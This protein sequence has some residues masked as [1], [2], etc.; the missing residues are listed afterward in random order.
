MKTKEFIKRI[1][2][3][4]YLIKDCYV[5]WQIRNKENSVVAIVDKNVL[6]KFSTDFNAWDYILDD[7]KNKLLSLIVE[8]TKTPAK[9]REEEKRYYLKHRYFRIAG[10]GSGFFTIA[11][12]SGLLFLKYK[13]NLD[14][15]S[16]KF[17][18]NEIEEIEEKYNTDL[19]DFELVEVEE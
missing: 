2:E 8:F 5:Y 6:F 3:L 14:N 1:E 16:Q 19:M 4:G 18:L 13:T 15:Y 7:D 10:G 9:Y 17:T 12:P 11:N